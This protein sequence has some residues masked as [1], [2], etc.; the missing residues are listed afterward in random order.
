MGPAS[1]MSVTATIAIGLE[2]IEP[3]LPGGARIYKDATGKS[4]F[5]D[6]PATAFFVVWGLGEKRALRA[7]ISRLAIESAIEQGAALEFVQ[8]AAWRT[9]ERF[10]AGEGDRETWAKVM[11]ID[12]WEREAS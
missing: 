3:E 5:S 11:G 10:A 6:N 1:M 7:D 12:T 8:R 2:G 4:V 9:S